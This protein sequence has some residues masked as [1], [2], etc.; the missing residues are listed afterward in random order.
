M[1]KTERDGSVLRLTLAR[2]DVRNAFNDELIA[3]LTS[4]FRDVDDSTRVVVLAGEGKSFCAGGDLEWMRKAAGYTE[5]QNVE[6]AM[7]LAGLFQS[8]VD[9]P[10]VVIARIHGAAFGGGCGLVAASDVAI[11]GRSALFCFSEVRLGLIPATIS[12]FVLPKIG[13]GNARW[14]FT[15]A[16]AFG[17]E[18]ALRIGLV[19]DVVDDDALDEGVANRVASVLKCGPQAVAKAKKLSVEGPYPLERS[20]RELAVARAGAEG[21]EG[22]GAFLEKRPATYVVD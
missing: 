5:E 22:V 9:C 4:A 20:A 1:L 11:V 16:E 18:T 12:N 10:A 13:N 2:P 8:M 15:T 6:D 3:A 17:P 21:Q 14:L 19:H 7:R